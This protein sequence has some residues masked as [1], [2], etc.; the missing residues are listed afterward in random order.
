MA[1]NL[2]F[3]SLRSTQYCEAVQKKGPNNVLSQGEF[4]ALVGN[5]GFKVV[6][7]SSVIPA[8]AAT[9]IALLRKIS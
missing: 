5:A 9:Y 4:D 6:T 3:V 7:R 8:V 2:L 1:D